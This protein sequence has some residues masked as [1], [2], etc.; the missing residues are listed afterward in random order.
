MGERV[1]EIKPESGG[2]KKRREVSKLSALLPVL[3]S[4]ILPR[5]EVSGK[6]Q[7]CKETV[8]MYFLDKE[9]SGSEKWLSRP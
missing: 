7:D 3:N 8:S 4:V 9:K 6:I 5:P 2:V 1:K